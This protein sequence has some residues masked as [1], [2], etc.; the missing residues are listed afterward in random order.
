MFTVHHRSSA[1]QFDQITQGQDSGD[2]ALGNPEQVSLVLAATMQGIATL[3]NGDMVDVSLLDELTDRAS[4]QVPRGAG[5]AWAMARTT[6]PRSD[7]GKAE[8]PTDDP[9]VAVRG[10]GEGLRALHSCRPVRHW[11]RQRSLSEGSATV[12]ARHV[13]TF[14]PRQ[15]TPWSLRST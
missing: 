15:E 10:G 13:A 9:A 2:V 4:D 6:P 11:V 1:R 8:R 7:P 12:S 3:I 5:P 14:R